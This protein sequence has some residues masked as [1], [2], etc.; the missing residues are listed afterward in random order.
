MSTGHLPTFILV[1]GMKCGTTSLHKYLDAHPEICMSTP[2]EPDYFTGASDRDADWYRQCFSEPA[3]EYGESSTNYTKYP[4]FQGVPERMHRLVPNVRLLYLVRDPIERALSHYTHNRVHGREEEP[5][6][7]AFLPVEDSHY[8][9]TSRYYMQI[10]QYLDYFPRERVLIVQSERLRNQRGAVM[11]R[12]FDFLGVSTA[13]DESRF[14]TEYHSTSKKLPPGLSSFLT[15]TRI[16]NAVTTLGEALVPRRLLDWGLEQFSAD[17][18]RPTLE[19]E[20]RQEVR[21]FLRRDAEQLRAQ[22]APDFRDW[23][24]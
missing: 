7:A 18:E 2:K 17:V 10:T 12:I 21:A 16:G 15:E 1:G 22:F 8:L 24:V 5:V 9:Q 19:G 11:R 13:I 20:V 6:E 23:S 4:T 3:A 14:D